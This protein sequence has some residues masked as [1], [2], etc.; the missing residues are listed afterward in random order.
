MEKKNEKERNKE[1]KITMGAKSHRPAG[2]IRPKVADKAKLWSS[3][4][5]S[6]YER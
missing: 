2:P 4:P 6:R 1:E 5:D 3:A